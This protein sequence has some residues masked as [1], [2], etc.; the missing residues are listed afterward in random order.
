MGLIFDLLFGEGLNQFVIYIIVIFLIAVA[1]TILNSWIGFLIPDFLVGLAW[2]ATI[3]SVLVWMS[4]N[5]L[6]NLASSLVGLSIL[7]VAG[8][9]IVVLVTAIGFSKS[10]EKSKSVALVPI[11]ILSPTKAG[12]GVRI[13][14]Q[15][16]KR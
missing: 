5:F 11:R 15:K 13:I 6:V 8:I 12:K 10:A 9:F 3:V 1:L 4:R 7:V 16:F 2:V 14:T